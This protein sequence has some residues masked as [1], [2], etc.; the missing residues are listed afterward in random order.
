M[1]K[2]FIYLAIQQV[3]LEN[4][5]IKA[6]SAKYKILTLEISIYLAIQHVFCV[7]PGMIMEIAMVMKLV[8]I[9]VI[10]GAYEL[11]KS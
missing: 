5:A 1:L 4:T 3:F 8:M 11:I 2:N 7:A 6:A 10:V 9:T